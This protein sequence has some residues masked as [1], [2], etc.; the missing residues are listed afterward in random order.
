[1]KSRINHPL[2]Q[3]TGWGEHPMVS[4]AVFMVIVMLWAT[5][6]P[7]N[8]NTQPAQHCQRQ[9]R[10]QT[11]SEPISCRRLTRFPGGRTSPM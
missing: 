11:K 7:A 8:T 5:N 6:I 1:V 2:I 3:A 9:P 4:R 10:I